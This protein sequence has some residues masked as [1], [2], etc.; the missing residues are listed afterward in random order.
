M[1]KLDSEYRNYDHYIQ[2]GWLSQPKESAKRLADTIALHLKRAEGQALDVGCATGELMAYL[3]SRFPELRWTGADVFD[4][5]IETGRR[6]L[7][8]A[9]FVK[10]SIL[11]PPESFR[12]QFDVVTAIGVM[13]I[14]DEEQLAL[15]WQNLLAAT[16]SGGLIVVLSPLNEY[17]IDALIRHRKRHNAQQLGWESGW[18]VYAM[19]TIKDLL[20][21]FGQTQV[22]FERFVFDQVLAPKQDPIR[23]WTLPTRDNP[24]Q[25]TNGLKLLVDHYFIVLRKR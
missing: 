3:G 17:G 1:T 9:R 4:E 6:L 15:F 5:L 10:A 19:E 21:S 24:H 23:T 22:T 2:E 18:N 20:S 16:K 14:F 13:S 11:E 12:N 7:P 25:L 8:S